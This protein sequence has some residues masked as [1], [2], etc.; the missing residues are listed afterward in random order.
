MR[1]VMTVPYLTTSAIMS[2]VILFSMLAYYV[3]SHQFDGPI[4]LKFALTWILNFKDRKV[5]Q[6]TFLYKDQIMIKYLG[7]AKN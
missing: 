2:K 7:F 6:P 1:P 3:N 5:F 4:I